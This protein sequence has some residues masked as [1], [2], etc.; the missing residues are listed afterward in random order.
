M[1][2]LPADFDPRVFV[3]RQLEAVTFAENVIV[4]S[5]GTGLTV[6]VSGS[7]PYDAGPG[8]GPGVDTPPVATTQ[9]VG[10][11]GQHV[12]AADLK[13]PRELVLC[14]GEAASLTLL[15]N[16]DHYECYIIS[17]GDSEVVV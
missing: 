12:R 14:L 9:L 13:S 5:F 10:L 15:D 6:S 17:F 3:D 11:V 16:N 1:Y 8:V 2:G 7:I 4:L